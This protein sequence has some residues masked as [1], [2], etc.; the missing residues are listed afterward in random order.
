MLL[1]VK[2]ASPDA[3]LYPEALYELGRA[4]M[5]DGKYQNAAAIY[6]Q[7]RV[8]TSDKTF[9]ARALIGKGMAYRNIKAY[10]TAL[11]QYKQVVSLVP[12]SEYAEE[13]M[14]AINS[15]Y[16]TTSTPRAIWIISKAAVSISVIR[17]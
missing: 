9:A 4:Y 5:E 10:D 1:A 14:L 16:Q 12:G 7:L 15:I 8:S 2:K 3:P 13:A 11:Q 17:I 6:E